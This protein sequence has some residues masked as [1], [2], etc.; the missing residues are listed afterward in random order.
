MK[1]TSSQNPAPAGYSRVCPYLMVDNIEALLIFL[2][3]V[4][5]AEITEKLTS[6]DGTVPHAEVHLGDSVIMIGKEQTGYPKESMTYVFVVDA[7]ATFK[8]AL[9]HGATSIM[10]P[11]DRFYGYREGGFKDP[12]GNQWWVAEVVENVSKEEMERRAASYDFKPAK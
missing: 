6:A 8:K 1:S 12:S 11:G 5:H 4:L 9:Q 2:K 10:E 3:E 7:D